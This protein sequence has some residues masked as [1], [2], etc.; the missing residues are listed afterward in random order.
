MSAA[1]AHPERLLY[2]LD[3]ALDHDIR[4]IIYGRSAIWLGFT[5]PPAAAASTVDVDGNHSN[6]ASPGTCP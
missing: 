3:E 4:L 2:A 5:E 6:R 1:L